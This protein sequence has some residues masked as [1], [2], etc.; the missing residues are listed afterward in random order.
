MKLIDLNDASLL[1]AKRSGLQ[2]RCGAWCAHD[3]RS[4]ALSQRIHAHMEGLAEMP[5]LDDDVDM[6]RAIIDAIISEYN[7]RIDAT[8]KS[9]KDLGVEL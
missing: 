1:A 8:E 5:L 3:V 7:K 6:C 9:M 2:D 4:P